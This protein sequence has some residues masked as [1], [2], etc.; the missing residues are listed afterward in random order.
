MAKVELRKPI[1]ICIFARVSTQKQDFTRQILELRRYAAEK[2][3]KVTR[4]IVSQ[5]SGSK[6]REARPDI[7]ELIKSAKNNEFDKI[8]CSEVSRLGR[9]AGD[10]RATLSSLHE[11]KIPIIFYSLGCLESIDHEG[12]ESFCTNIILA[13][14]SELAQEERRI[15]SE[16]TRS[17]LS[18]A[19][20][21][22]KKLGRPMGKL[23]EHELLQK[24]LKIVRNLQAGQT[25]S[26][27]AKLTNRSYNTIKRIKL[28]L[29]LKSSK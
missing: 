25:V 5:V 24:H 17:G 23:S 11:L 21:K 18:A 27:T 12:K 22:G 9:N 4:E 28:I 26:D 6:T 1:R 20:A 2:G 7:R 19:I 3:Y 13:I 8:L 10:V 14:Y 15:L 29:D 16:R